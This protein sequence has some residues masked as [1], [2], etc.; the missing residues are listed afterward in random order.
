[1][2][3]YLVLLLLVVVN[4]ILSQ[5]IKVVDEFDDPIYNVGFYNT[6]QTILKFS[7][8]QGTID[9]SEFGYNDSIIIQHPSF[10][11]IKILKSLINGNKIKLKSKIINIDEVIFSVNKWEESINEVTNKAIILSEQKI[12]EIAPQTSADL[13]EKSGEV[14]VQKSQLGGG[15][16]MIRGF[17]ANRI[18]LTLDGVRLNNIIYRSGNLHNIIGIDPNIL[19][20][21][22]VLFGPASVIYGS[23]ALGGAI[24]FKIKDPI[25]NSN[26]TVF[27]NSQKIQYNSSSNSK[28][29]S[30]NFG[31]N[32]KKIGTITSFSF[33]SFQD[34]RSGAKRNKNYKNFGFR[35]EF[36]IRDHTNDTDEIIINND[37]N[38]QKFSG[39]SQLDFINKINFKINNNMNLIHGIYLSKSSNIPRY[40]RLILYDNII[41]PKY[42]EWFYGPNYFLMNKIQLNNFK[43]TKYYD[44]FKFNISNQIIKESRHSRRFN[45]NYINNRNE[46]VDVISFNLDFDKKY[47]ND[48]I[49]YGYE[50]IFN[51]VNSEGNRNNI[52]NDESLKISSRYPAGGTVYYSNSL[53]ISYKKKIGKIFSNI[54]LRGNSSNL[55]SKLTNE[56]FN[57]PFSEINLNTSSFSG[58][59]GLRY[60]NKNSSFKIQ[61]S[62]GF[63][64]PN[65]DDLGKVFD[66]EPGNII[67][68]NANLEPEHVN[69][70]EFNYE[71]QT[72]KFK[73][74]NTLFY[75]KLNNA[76]IRTEGEF[77]GKDSIVYDG[78]LSKIQ[79]LNNGGKAYVYGFSNFFKIKLNTVFNL[80]HTISFNTSKDKINNRPLRHSTPLFG[81]LSLTY[82][83]RKVKIGYKINYNG[84]KKLEDFSLSELNK[85]YLYTQHGSPS[86]VTHNLFFNLNYNYFIN[87]DFGIDNI[88][89]KHYRT[90]SSGISAPGRNIRVGLNLKF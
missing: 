76:I 15:S 36:V 31:F 69:N 30:L 61:Y 60:N 46:K 54:G 63:R 11:N 89:D 24:N 7:N 38:I 79:Q 20:G 88:F 44:A 82:S 55:E 22:E 67:I 56:F 77:N 34:L 19:E 18:L 72:N 84:K 78:I 37:R 52:L 4:P 80:E 47:S 6:A 83:K 66:S 65:L 26:K 16:P 71:F 28:H 17:G 50:F 2:E 43:K 85:L 73:V 75:V 86:W 42:S 51:N 25:F 21:V 81:M 14:F 87:F 57:F 33:N 13:L 3:K 68:P 40:D 64:S 90:Y 8:F 41:T 1:M 12:K 27:F 49:F 10:E 45:S 58:N 70:Y 9:L 29:Y 74:I 32:S 62:N 5:N 35:D 59:V 39:Y 23:D 53:Y 48:E